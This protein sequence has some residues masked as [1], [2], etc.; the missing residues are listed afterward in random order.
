MRY[1]FF[2]SLLVKGGEFITSEAVRTA[3]KPSPPS[4]PFTGVSGFLGGLGLGAGL[5]AEKPDPDRV[6][7]E[8]FSRL[9]KEQLEAMVDWFSLDGVLAYKMLGLRYF[10]DAKDRIRSDVDNE[11]S[12][13]RRRSEEKLFAQLGDAA[14]PTIAAYTEKDLNV[15]IRDRYIEA[16]LSILVA[17]G[18]KDDVARARPRLRAARTSSCRQRE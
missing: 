16:A 11:F 17:H 2:N 15:W 6:L 1:G 12:E 10:D 9:A 8:L 18:N 5:F 3:L 14:R 4:N 13:L 7:F